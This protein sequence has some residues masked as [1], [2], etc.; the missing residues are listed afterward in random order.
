[1]VVEEVV[2]PL[3]MLIHPHPEQELQVVLVDLVEVLVGLTE[4]LHHFIPLMVEVLL[5][6]H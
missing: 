4:H 1:M 2:D 6:V 5:Q 3:Y